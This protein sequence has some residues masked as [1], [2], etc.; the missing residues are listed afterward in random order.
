M[1]NIISSFSYLVQIQE[2]GFKDTNAHS[3]TLALQN[4]RIL[5]LYSCFLID[6]QIKRLRFNS[7]ELYL[8]R[9]SSVLFI[10]RITCGQ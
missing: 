2:T 8:R 5:A 6:Y 10:I 9:V 3:S 7:G 1:L 4:R